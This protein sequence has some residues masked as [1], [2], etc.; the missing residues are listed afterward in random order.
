MAKVICTLPNASEEISG[1]KFNQV[2]GGMLSEDV[3]DDVAARFASIK[4]YALVV[5]KA[6]R[7]ADKAPADDQ[8]DAQSAAEREELN[9]LADKAAALGV[10]VKSNWKSG[11]LKAEIEKAEAAAPAPAAAEAALGAQE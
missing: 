1:V 3:A 8:D 6:T 5:E 11:R 10:A 9:A 4:G 2:D 7:P